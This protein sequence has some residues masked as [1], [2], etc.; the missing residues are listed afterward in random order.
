MEGEAM[1]IKRA[2]LP[3]IA[4]T[5]ALLGMAVFAVPASADTTPTTCPNGFLGV[6]NAPQDLVV[7]AGSSCGLTEGSTIGRDVIVNQGG[8]FF[9]GGITIGRDL[10][11]DHPNLIE[12]G[13]PNNGSTETVVGRDVTITDTTGTLPFGQFICQTQVGRN[14]TVTGTVT[15]AAWD[16]GTPLFANCARNSTPGDSIGADGVFTNNAV[17]ISVG[18]STFGHDLTF[19]GNT[20]SSNDLISNVISH[21]CNQSG[22]HPFDGSGNTAGSSIDACNSVNA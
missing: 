3:L 22:N 4:V 21:D 17:T 9:V 1:T 6:L 18:S 5:A 13:D 19:T 16:I 2:L 14:L 11:A 20:G 15:G 8:S 7:P 10:I 12:L